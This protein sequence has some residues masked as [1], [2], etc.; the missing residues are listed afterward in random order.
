MDDTYLKLIDFL[1]PQG[2]YA[3]NSKEKRIL[4]SLEQRKIV[5]KKPG[6]KFVYIK[7]PKTILDHNNNAKKINF[8]QLLKKSFRSLRTNYKPFVSINE[9]RVNFTSSHNVSNQ[10]FNTQLLFLY[11]EGLVEMEQ[12]L[13]NNENEINGIQSNN[14]KIFQYITDVS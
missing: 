13:T 8:S 9:I 6:T 12:A 11:E 3:R 1:S 10:Y 7:E 14:G 4:K 5:S 2:Y